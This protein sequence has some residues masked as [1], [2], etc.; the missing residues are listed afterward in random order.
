MSVWTQWPETADSVGKSG[1]SRVIESECKQKR[2][3]QRSLLRE[4]LRAHKREIE[5]NRM[6]DSG[7]VTY[8]TSF[9]EVS[10]IFCTTIESK[11]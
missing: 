10:Y 4:G 8:K 11:L 5:E 1:N 9:I 7:T 6:I 2:V 3:R